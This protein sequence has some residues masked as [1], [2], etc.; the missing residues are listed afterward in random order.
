MNHEKHVYQAIKELNE[1]LG[2]QTITS[3][4]ENVSDMFPIGFDEMLYTGRLSFIAEPAGKT[5]IFAIADY[6]ERQ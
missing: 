4:L 5:R 1:V 6:L 3:W 2:Q